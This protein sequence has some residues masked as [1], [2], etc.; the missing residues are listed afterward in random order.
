MPGTN[1]STGSM[2]RPMTRH[3][4]HERAAGRPS[5]E[6]RRRA[7]AWRGCRNVCRRVSLVRM[8]TA[9]T[10]CSRMAVLPAVERRAVERLTA[11]PLFRR[12]DDA[13]RDAPVFGVSSPP[14]P[15]PPSDAGR[16]RGAGV[17]RRSPSGAAPRPPRR[18]PAAACGLLACSHSTGCALA[19]S[20]GLRVRALARGRASAAPLDPAMA[21]TL[22]AA[23][24]G[25]R[26][27]FPQG[28]A[29]SDFG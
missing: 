11:A 5:V 26:I 16:L 15:P 6:P 10:A 17:R 19:L 4:R 23:T 1:C 28:Y 13:R 21:T 20:D 27:R 3:G 18:A 9:V 24:S 25:V 14:S 7:R 29:S 22:Q 2:T 12:H 8:P